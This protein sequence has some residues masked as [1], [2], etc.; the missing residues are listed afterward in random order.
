MFKLIMI[1][2]LFFSIH[3]QAES[4]KPEQPA[5][6]EVLKKDQEQ[7]KRK[8]KEGNGTKVKSSTEIEKGTSAGW[9][10][11]F[12]RK[13][14]KKERRKTKRKLRKEL[15]KIKRQQKKELIKKVLE[16]RKRKRK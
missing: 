16:R 15:R 12:E 3:L 7:P 10:K 14:V 8:P 6:K 2:L 1:L 13:Q 11:M 4:V 5:T 9:E